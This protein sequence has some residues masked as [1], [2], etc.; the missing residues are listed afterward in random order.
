MKEARI[1][2]KRWRDPKHPVIRSVELKRRLEAQ[3]A[4]IDG[5]RGSLRGIRA[6]DLRERKDRF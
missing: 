6:I 5:F 2:R 3:K 1:A 4:F